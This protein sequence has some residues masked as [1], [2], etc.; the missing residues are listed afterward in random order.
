MDKMTYLAELRQLASVTRVF[1]DYA[2]VMKRI[3]RVC[4]SIEHDIGLLQLRVEENTQ[5][6]QRLKCGSA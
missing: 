5:P 2:H 1:E 6:Y 3:E 4:D